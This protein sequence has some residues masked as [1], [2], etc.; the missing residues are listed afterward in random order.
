LGLSELSGRKSEGSKIGNVIDYSS[1]KVEAA[2]K[3]RLNSC[4]QQEEL[5]PAFKSDSWLK[6]PFPGFIF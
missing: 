2:G 3:S 6:L 4:H 5:S 1:L